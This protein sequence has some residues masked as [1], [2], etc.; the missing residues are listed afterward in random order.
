MI[1]DNYID[2]LMLSRKIKRMENNQN[3]NIEKLYRRDYYRIIDMKKTREHITDKLITI[4]MLKVQIM[5]VLCNME[6]MSKS[7]SYSYL[8]QHTNK[9]RKNR[10][11]C[12]IKVR[13]V[14]DNVITTMTTIV[15]EFKDKKYLVNLSDEEGEE[16]Y[17]DE[18]KIMK[19]KGG[20]TSTGDG[21]TGV[22]Y[23]Y[24]KAIV[25]IKK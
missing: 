4:E 13:I 20:A 24:I 16:D 23:N 25:F 12:N 9:Q 18:I 19:N 15:D 1:D 8:S 5:N 6:D 17:L 21:P 11:V 2:D 7:A 3:I 22:V 14:L 10:A